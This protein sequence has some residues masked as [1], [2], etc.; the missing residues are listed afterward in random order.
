MKLVTIGIPFFNSE[1]SLRYA[2]KS[3]QNQT[4]NN[5]EIIL[6]NDGSTD[7]SLKIA[8]EMTNQ[9]PRI[10]VIQIIDIARGELIARMDADDMIHPERIEKQVKVLE[11]NVLIDVVSTGMISL[12]EKFL[13]IGQRYCDHTKQNIFKVFK[14]GEGILHASLLA[15]SDW[16]RKNKY[17]EGFERAEDRELFT[18]TLKDSFY[19]NIPVPLYFYVDVPN[20]NLKKFLKSYHSERK[21]LLKN[22]KGSISRINFI[23]LLIRSFAKE[24]I[25]SLIFWLGIEKKIFLS[26][27]RPILKID[28]E[29]LKKIIDSIIYPFE[30][31]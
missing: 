16:W 4:Y 23:R 20:M 11:E 1:R 10:I 19:Y 8:Q 30:K 13:P 14:N 26:K 2:I 15:K 17:E 28:A 27:N 7:N 24:K 18:R 9:D 12:D 5:L 6:I 31:R 21:A 29:N 25:I 3:V 22:W